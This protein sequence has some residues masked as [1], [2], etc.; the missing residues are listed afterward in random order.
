MDLRARVTGA[1]ARRRRPRA[2]GPGGLGGDPIELPGA[3]S[4]PAPP[5]PLAATPL[6]LQLL[7]SVVDDVPAA[8]APPTA[9]ALADARRPRPRRSSSCAC[10]RRSA[11]PATA[12]TPGSPGWP[13]ARSPPSA[14]ATGRAADRRL[15]LGRASRAATTRHARVP[16]LHPRALAGARRHGG[17]AARGLERPRLA[18]PR[19]VD[20][21]RPAL[22]ARPHRRVPARRR[23]PRRHA[24]RPARL[25]LRAPPARRRLDRFI[26]DCRR[27]V[28]ESQGI[29]RAPRGPVDGLELAELYHEPG[30]RI[31]LPD[32]TSFTVVP[33]IKA[34]RPPAPAC[35]ARSTTCSGAWTRWPTPRS[36]TPSTTSFRATRST[37]RPRSTASPPAPCRR[38]GWAGSNTPVTGRQR[39]A[40][41]AG[42]ARRGGAPAPR[43][44]APRRAPSSSP[45]CRPGSPACSAIRRRCAAR[46][47]SLATGERVSVTL[48]DLRVSPLDAVFESLGT[49]ERRARPTC[50]PSP[51]T[52]STRAGSWWRPPPPASPRGSSA[53]SRPR[54]PRRC[55][56]NAGRRRRPL[57]AR[58]LPCP[59]PSSRAAPTWRRRGAACRVPGRLEDGGDR[60]R[61]S[62]FRSRPS[63]TR[64]PSARP[65][66]PRSAAP[67][68]RWRASASRTRCR[69][70]ATPS[71]AGRLCTPMP[72]R[73]WARPRA[74][75]DAD[76]PA[77]GRLPPA[78]PLLRRR[79]R[80]S[81]TPSTAVTT[82]LEGDPAAAMGW[83]RGVARVRDG[84][85]ALERA[86]TLD[87]LLHDEAERA[88]GG[89]PAARRPGRAVGGA[90]R[91]ARPAPRGALVAR[92]RPRRLG[93]LAKA[94]RAAAGLVVDEWVE[95]VPSGE[96]VTG[97]ALN[98]DAPSSRP[99][100]AML[101]GLPPARPQLELRQRRGHAPR[102]ARG[103]QAAGRRSRRPA[104]LRPP[105]PRSTRRWESTPA[106]RRRPMADPFWD[107]IEP[108]TR[109]PELEEGLQA[110]AR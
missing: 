1:G 26:D 20:G 34:V 14:R 3:T 72:G 11:S 99:P 85:A 91:A 36:P 25:P 79:P 35:R 12:S 67:S 49:W 64:R 94:G 100:Q 29:T 16:G 76:T 93:D 86:I 90:A 84:A 97:V 69:C 110:R 82:L 15:R 17:R 50:W 87:E 57:D 31:D 5:P 22:G 23:P 46:S 83:L 81:P 77:R 4:D 105:C 28:L 101:L 80:A 44:G 74:R 102:G 52:P 48:A 68:A 95:L 98:V 109:D 89:R 37:H 10:A 6:L 62:S 45:R 88:A 107:R 106:R 60:A 27:R 41:A 13:R 63:R 71:R 38:P 19:V 56:A 43:A 21:R 51:P 78:A 53:S 104:R 55:A 39:V 70:T 92:P 61:A 33:G 8:S 24:G 9:S 42:D 65:A 32:G 59:P 40:P 96:V 66:W 73:P 2:R 58:D 47:R 18:R 108:H 7:D 103:G 75:L 30:V 54:R